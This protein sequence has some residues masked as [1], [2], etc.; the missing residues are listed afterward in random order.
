MFT[1]LDLVN[2]YLGYFTTN[3]KTKDKIYTSVSAV[4]VWYLLYIAYR[5]FVNGR[6]LRGML[7]ALVFVLLA[8]FVILNIVYYFTNS[9]MKWDISPRIE[10][11]LGG[12]QHVVEKAHPR[13]V[14]VPANGLYQRQDVM[15]GEITVDGTQQENITQ[16]ATALMQLGFM[17][18]DYGHLGEQA[19]RQIISQRAVIFANHPG[20]LLPYFDMITVDG[21]TKVMGGVNQL[22]ASDLGTLITVGMTPTKQALAQYRL[23][24]SSVIITGGMGHVA[25]RTALL[26]VQQP[27]KV[28][29]E[30]AYKKKN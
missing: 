6:W 12:P 1:L 24:L 7:I 29:V 22:Q 23:A 13:E 18:Q 17:Q 11:A 9:V 20:T 25:T 21:E 2:H 14:I 19:Q 28:Q 4:G 3:S 30:V 15:T 16:L 5:F 10:K 27:Y 8:Y 26:A